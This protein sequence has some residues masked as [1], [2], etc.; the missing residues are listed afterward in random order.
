V[1]ARPKAGQ[2]ENHIV[3]HAASAQL[4]T[5]PNVVIRLLTA[6]DPDQAARAKSLFEHETI[7]LAKTV[8]LETEWV[9]RRLYGFG[10]GQVVAA[11]TALVALL[12]GRCEDEAGVVAAL[13]WTTRGLDFADALHLASARSATAITTFDADLVRRAGSAA[14]GI[15]VTAL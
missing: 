6:D 10:R 7:R 14:A 13:E 11:L 15:A 12:N 4:T 1:D 8:I 3:G 9:L 5:G 2:D